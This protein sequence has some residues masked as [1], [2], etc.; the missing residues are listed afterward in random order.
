MAVAYLSTPNLQRFGLSRSQWYYSLNVNETLFSSDIDLQG[1]CE[2]SSV[3]K[4]KNFANNGSF[5]LS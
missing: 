4:V 2:G 5:R 1:V 3:S